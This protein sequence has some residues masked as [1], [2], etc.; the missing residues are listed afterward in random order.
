ML[1][2]KGC[3]TATTWTAPFVTALTGSSGI[4][5]NTVEDGSVAIFCAEFP[6]DNCA[7]CLGNDSA[8]PRS[9]SHGQELN[10]VDKLLLQL[11]EVDQQLNSRQ[12]QA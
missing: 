4:V 3:A 5:A 7:W 1:F 6:K 9:C 10:G 11:L 8:R 12:D 2:V